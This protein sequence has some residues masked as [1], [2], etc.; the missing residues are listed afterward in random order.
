MIDTEEREWSIGLHIL[1]C[2][3]GSAGFRGQSNG[4]VEQRLGSWNGIHGAGKSFTS[5]GQREHS[6]ATFTRY[7]Q[8]TLISLDPST[9]L[10][11]A[12]PA[13]PLA[14]PENAWVTTIPVT[15]GRKCSVLS[16]SP[17]PVL[18]WQKMLVATSTWASTLYS[19]TWKRTATPAG[20]LLFRL[21]ASTPSTNGTGF[22]SW[23][24]A[25][26]NTR[27]NEGNV[28]L[29]RAKVRKGEMSEDEAT[30]ILG[31][32]PMKAQGKIPAAGPTP[33][34]EGFDAG[35]HRG[36]PD[37]LHSAVKSFPTPNASDHRDRGSWEDNCTQRRIAIGKQVGLTATVQTK[38]MPGK[39]HGRWTLA[40][41]GF[42][43]DWCDDLPPD[44]LT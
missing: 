27:P 12:T 14:L 16:I 37:S 29:L 8:M 35:A 31:K 20:R 32:S 2:S 38:T 25:T 4:L 23:P 40:L 44:P 15:S 18:S 10:P 6:M 22:G 24:T 19:L 42:D 28:R 7:H 41:M 34:H 11:E 21:Q 17:D 3:P 13:S 26:A 5:I 33:R 43:P 9:S 39:L 30:A 1:I 36:M